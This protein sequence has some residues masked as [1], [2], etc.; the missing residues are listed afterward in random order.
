M[1]KLSKKDLKAIIVTLDYYTLELK[2]IHLSE[3]IGHIKDIEELEDKVV[4]LQNELFIAKLAPKLEAQKRQPL[5]E[6]QIE[7]CA[8]E[9]PSG[10][11]SIGETFVRFARAIEAAHGIK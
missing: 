4:Q 3:R 10:V 8:D 7:T 5:T 11:M 9:L 2:N 6:K 1:S